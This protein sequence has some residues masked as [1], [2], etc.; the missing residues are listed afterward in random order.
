M[1]SAM[2]AVPARFAPNPHRRA[3]LA[4]VH[5]AKKELGLVDDDYRAVLVDVAGVTSAA[6]CTDGQLADLLERFKARGFQSRKPGESARNRRA[7]PRP[8][9]HPTARKARA[10]WISLHQLGAIGNP[11]ERALETFAQRQL[12]CERL[13]W[14]DQ[15]L[16]YKLI[17]ALKAIAER[18]S[19]HHGD[20]PSLMVLKL[21]LANAILQKLMQAG[22]VPADWDL[23]RA[24]WSLLGEKREPRHRPWEM[25]ELD[26]I[27][28]G[29]GDKLRGSRSAAS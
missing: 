26:V 7:A 21:R 28:R 8:A 13:Q 9:D 12:G 20:S 14:A 2:K 16:A 11:S 15:S 1:P 29:L 18:H 22:L 23:D 3:M 4:K 10:L 27:A 25:G 24:A 19:W 6:D 17:E 5:L